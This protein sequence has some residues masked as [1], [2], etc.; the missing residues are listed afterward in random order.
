MADY[1]NTLNLPDT[2]FPMKGD[3]AKREPERVKQ[4][5]ESKL[6]ERIRRP[7]SRAARSSCCTTGRP[8]PTATS[9]SGTRSTRSSRTSSSR[10]RSLAGF[11]A[12]YVP[13]W[14]CHG[15]PIEHQVEKRHG[16]EH[17][18]R[19][20]PP[21][22]PGVRAPSRSSASAA[23]SS[24]SACSATGSIP[25]SRWTSGPKR[26]SSARSG[27]CM[28]AAT[29]TRARSRCTGAS[30]AGRRWPNAEVEYEDRTS[31][32]IDVAFPFVDLKRLARAFGFTHL[33]EPAFA[34]IWTTTPWTLPANQAVAV[35]P[36]SAL[37]PGAHRQGPAG[38]GRGLARSLPAALRTDRRGARHRTRHALDL[39]E[40]HAPVLRSQS[41]DRPRRACHAGRRH[42][43]GTHRAGSWPGGLSPSAPSTTCRS[44]IPSMTTAASR[45]TCARGRAHGVG[46][47]RSDHRS[48]RRR[49]AA[50]S[51]A[52]RSQHS[53]PHCWRHKT[54]IIFRATPQWF[55]GDGFE[56]SPRRR[57][58]AAR[59]CAKR[60]VAQP[61]S[62]PVGGVRAWLAWSTTVPTGASRASATGA[63]P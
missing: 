31:P 39:L 19:A 27:A 29:C 1:K 52:R 45:P 38:A 4:W 24:A 62:F 25:T 23:I 33:Y 14:D 22:V 11:D 32:A 36:G 41:A 28:R 8:M 6:Y 9:T 13:G 48:A 60:S 15:L 57:P 49:Q 16:K 26:T 58:A 20:I 30:T 37:Q 47:E 54:P 7:R 43:A 55:I 44:T 2:G 3:L 56:P 12:P 63:R 17:P 34:V 5:Q 46:S 50:C 21:A 10:A 18:G 53:Y 61:S 40:L 51:N 42:R 35:H 59:D